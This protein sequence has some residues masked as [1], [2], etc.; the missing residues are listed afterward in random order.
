MTSQ[1]INKEKAKK[2][3]VGGLF[4]MWLVTKGKKDDQKIWKENWGHL[5]MNTKNRYTLAIN[6]PRMGYGSFGNVVSKLW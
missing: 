2:G 4:K 3:R 5:W 6:T 1:R